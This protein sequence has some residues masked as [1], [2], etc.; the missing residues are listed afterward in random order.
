MSQLSAQEEEVE[1]AFPPGAAAVVTAG[2]QGIGLAIGEALVEVGLALA[3]MDLDEIAGNQAQAR[4][5]AHGTARFVHGDAADEDAVRQLVRAGTELGTLT[6]AVANAGISIR[7]PVT[8]LSRT[9]WDRVLAVNLTGGFL[10]AKHTAPHLAA[11]H[12]AM[13]LIA[14]TRA[15]Q[16][17]PNWEAYGASKGGV[18]ALTHALAV[19][20]GPRVRVNCV[21]PGWIETGP[22]QR[23]ERVRVPQHSDADRA[24]HP[25]GR[26]GEPPDVARL[27]CYLASPA[28]GFITGQNFIVDGGMTR[29]M[30][31]V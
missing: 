1:S 9:E 17:E 29:K 6:V 22:W 31:Y 7:K 5:A 21:S 10:L 12:G 14:S 16:S 19:S 20:L 23:A 24:Q 30:S 28:A 27:V 2:A 26:V 4:L 25:A 8:A 3:F 11:A 13:V 18:V 15:L